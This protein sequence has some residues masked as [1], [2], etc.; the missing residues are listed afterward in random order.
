MAFEIAITAFR[1]APWGGTGVLDYVVQLGVDWEDAA[2]QWAFAPEPGA[3]ASFVLV[4]E[5]AGSQGVSA[6]YQADY[7]H[8]NSG[9]I[10]GATIITP[11][12]TQATFAELPDPVPTSADIVLY[13]TLYVTPPGGTKR[14]FCFGDFVIKQG[15]PTDA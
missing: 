9:A 4:N 14:V 2:F 5:A 7:V 12:I 6:E 11:L 8:P 3:A 10:V 1:H 15:A 13:H